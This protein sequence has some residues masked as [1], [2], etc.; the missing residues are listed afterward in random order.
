VVNRT[1][2]R[3]HALVSEFCASS[4]HT[5]LDAGGNAA[6]ASSP[7]WDLVINATASGLQDAAP[8]LPDGVYAPGALAY[9]MVYGSHPTPFM[10]EAAQ[11]GARSADGLG[12]LVEQAAESFRIWRGVMPDTAPVLTTL[13]AALAQE[14]TASDA[15]AG[16]R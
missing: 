3:A 16:I 11:A 8:D 15:S 5:R 13:R 1:E 2:S 10:R 9:D 12:M 14:S 7:G 4:G 6:A